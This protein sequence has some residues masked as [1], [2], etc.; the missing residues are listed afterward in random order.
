MA[1]RLL[2]LVNESAYLL[3]HRANIAQAA[4]EAGF[5]VHV[6]T[7]LSHPVDEIERLGIRVHPMEFPR[8]LRNPAVEL[9]AACQLRSIYA[10]VQPDLVNHFSAKAVLLGSLAARSLRIPH[11]I[12]TF[13]G[14]GSVFSGRGLCAMVRRLLVRRGMSLLLRSPGWQ[15]TFQNQEDMQQLIAEGLIERGQCHLIRGSGVDTALYWPQP[16]PAGVTTFLFAARMIWPKGV[17]QFVEAARLVSATRHD[18]RFVLAGDSDPQN[19]HAVPTRQLHAWQAEGVIQWWGRQT[20]MP[21]TIRRSNV[22]VLPTYYGEGLPRILLEAAACGRPAITTDVRGCR[23]AVRHAVTG[24]LVP[25]ADVAAL[26]NAMGKLADQPALRRRMGQAGRTLVVRE[27]TAELVAAK[28]MA[29]YRRMLG[30]PEPIPDA[31]H[32]SR[33]AA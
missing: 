32:T 24:L 1:P 3:S 20:D 17:G 14:L 19:T 9:R 25:P 28:T 21:A 30:L 29:I 10:A 31:A 6:V 12:N 22:V 27:F 16:E 5:D 8:N 2:L 26:A 13:T 4:I 7:R 11:V 18:V 33:R 23:D 15:A